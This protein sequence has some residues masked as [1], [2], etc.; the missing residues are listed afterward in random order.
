MWDG[1]F[2]QC[3]SVRDVC[4]V[5]CVLVGRGVVLL[6]W[7]GLLSNQG[8]PGSCE[9]LPVPYSSFLSCS[10]YV[11]EVPSVAHVMSPCFPL[12]CV[13][14]QACSSDRAPALGYCWS[15][16]MI[17]RCARIFRA[18]GLDV[19][20]DVTRNAFGGLPHCSFTHWIVIYFF[21]P[22]SWCYFCILLIS[23]EIRETEWVLLGWDVPPGAVWFREGP[24]KLQQ[25]P[26]LRHCI[27]FPPWG[28]GGCVLRQFYWQ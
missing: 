12:W 7:Q 27:A 24:D 9:V 28:A 5:C 6:R 23:W 14:I 18:G 10:Q 15:A 8:T 13:W 17:W 2:W 26:M 11:L 4:E 3:W 22:A 16:H 25:P 19:W 1:D 21:F 20:W